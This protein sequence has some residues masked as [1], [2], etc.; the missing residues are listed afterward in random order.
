LRTTKTENIRCH[1]DRVLQENV[2]FSRLSVFYSLA[3]GIFDLL[4]LV[5]TLEVNSNI[6]SCYILPAACGERKAPV[7]YGVIRPRMRYTLLLATAARNH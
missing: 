3:I 2:G 5:S 1:F 7:S 4:F 6:I